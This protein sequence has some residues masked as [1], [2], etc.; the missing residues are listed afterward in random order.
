LGPVEAAEVEADR[1]QTSLQ[2]QSLELEDLES[3]VTE[4]CSAA[5]L[6]AFA[7]YLVDL[8]LSHPLKRGCRQLL[9]QRGETAQVHLRTLNVSSNGNLNLL[10]SQRL[11][12]WRLFHPIFQ[13]GDRGNQF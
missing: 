8:L 6:A 3:L 1:R 12:Q 13:N 4:A 10:A 7:A 9:P 5:L 11:Q 2:R